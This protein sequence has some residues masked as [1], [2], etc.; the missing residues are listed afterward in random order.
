MYISGTTVLDVEKPRDTKDVQG[1]ASIPFEMGSVI[2]VNNVTGT[3]L[4]V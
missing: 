2:K 4:L 1:T 3:P